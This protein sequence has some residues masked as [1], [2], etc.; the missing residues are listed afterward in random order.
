MDDR[1]T[2]L[3]R[4]GWALRAPIDD[5][6]RWR[7]LVMLTDRADASGLAYPRI[8]TVAADVRRTER[9]TRRALDSL[10]DDGYVARFRLRSGGRLRGYLWRVLAPG[11]AAVDPETLPRFAAGVDLPDEWRRPVPLYRSPTTASEGSSTGHTRPVVYR[12]HATGQEPPTEGTAHGEDPNGSSPVSTGSAV[13]AYDPTRDPDYGF[14]EFWQAFPR[15][16]G[17]RQGKQEAL[18]RWRRLSLDDRR[19]AYRGAIAYAAHI[20]AT[21]TLAMD[22]SR[23]LLRRFFDDYLDE[24]VDAASAS[25]DAGSS[26]SALDAAYRARADEL[27]EEGR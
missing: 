25:R 14:A 19:R 1:S 27:R 16:H 24:P 6:T 18:K 22:A 4:L 26:L 23:F 12:S 2:A 11:V 7:V 5:P 17:R 15:R 20:D 10:V 3:D 21:D 8:A 13:E 9:P